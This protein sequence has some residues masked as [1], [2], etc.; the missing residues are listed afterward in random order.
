MRKFDYRAARYS[1]DL[2]V[3]LTQG[4]STHL[5]RCR[6][7]STEGMKLESHKPLSP[8]SCGALHLSFEEFDIE[9]SIEVTNT[10]VNFGGV[11][12]IYQSSEQRDTISQLLASLITPRPCTSL[13]LLS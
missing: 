10:G 12:F 4:D 9:L 8:G 11:R 13:A 7:I 6:E 3:R 1:V 5:V 2:A